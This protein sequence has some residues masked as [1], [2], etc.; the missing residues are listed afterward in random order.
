[1]G[2]C[3][4]NEKQRKNEGMEKQRKEE[5]KA[6]EE[7]NLKQEIKISQNKLD[8]IPIKIDQY[9][10]P[11]AQN[12]KN[13]IND[14]KIKFN[15]DA[16]KE[17]N[18]Y[19]KLHGAEDLKL[20]ES[21]YQKAFTLAKQLLTDGYFDNSNLLYQHL[22]SIGLNT[23]ESEEELTPKQLM[24]KWYEEMNDYN[25]QEP[26]ELNCYNFTQMI[27]KNS[28]FFG[29][30]Y[31][32]KTEN[33]ENDKLSNPTSPP[34]K[35]FYAALYFPAGNK[36]E[37]YKDNVLKKI[38]EKTTIEK[39]TEQKIDSSKDID[40]NPNVGNMD[41]SEKKEEGKIAN[42]DKLKNSK[43]EEER[44]NVNTGNSNLSKNKENGKNANAE[45]SNLPKKQEEGKNANDELLNISEKEEEGKK[46]ENTNVNI[47]NIN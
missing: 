21:L 4:D 44:K 9:N 40:N 30:G 1:M 16:L 7:L 18:T 47:S 38:E 43:K 23:F 24:S 33:K 13:E 39:T 35:Y 31:F 19:R 28:K 26:D 46:P 29:I 20:D 36:K 25:F 34:R 11:D 17:N 10:F 41:L 22:E 8:Y 45:N 3:G 5:K 12:K 27:W 15:E 42:E 37:E 14:E 2:C 32:S 6:K